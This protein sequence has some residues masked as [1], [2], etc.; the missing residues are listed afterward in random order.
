M[1]R[2]FPDSLET[3]TILSIPGKRNVNISDSAN[4]RGVALCSVYCKIFDN[5]ILARYSD[6][7]T[8][9]ELQLG[10]KLSILSVNVRLF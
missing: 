1:C 8:S 5:V 4:Y 10:L 6:K 7:I 3:C 2:V 9:A